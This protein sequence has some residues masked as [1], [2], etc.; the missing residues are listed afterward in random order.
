MNDGVRFLKVYNSNS[1]KRHVIDVW[2]TERH[3]TLCGLLYWNY[4]FQT[5]FYNF[6]EP[7]ELL[8]IAEV[9]CSNCGY[10]ISRNADQFIYESPET[11]ALFETIPEDFVFDFKTPLHDR[12][13]L[14]IQYPELMNALYWVALPRENKIFVMPY[15]GKNYMIDVN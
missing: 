8:D 13:T 4:Q 14:Q 3:E 1:G 10:I 12:I 6:E 9:D 11:R 15:H 7:T 5:P 2:N